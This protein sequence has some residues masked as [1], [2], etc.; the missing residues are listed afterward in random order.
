MSVPKLEQKG[1]SLAA[2]YT[3]ANEKKAADEVAA[4]RCVAC[5]QVGQYIAGDKGKKRRLDDLYYY[6]I[7]M[8]CKCG[9]IHFVY[10][11]VNDIDKNRNKRLPSAVEALTKAQQKRL[12]PPPEYE[13][14]LVQTKALAF[15]GETD[16]ALQLARACAQQFPD[17]AP[18][19][20]NYGCMLASVHQYEKALTCFTQTLALDENFSSAW[21][22]Q[23][24]IQQAQGNY[25][26]AIVCYEHFLRKYPQHREAAQRKRQCEQLKSGEQ[27][28]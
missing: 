21:Y 25:E 7:G 12:L 26:R 4:H 5:G 3:A 10:L 2:A 1:L 16:Q 9:F 27:M 11:V 23:A 8:K 22:Q 13:T 6:K 24:L 14:M 19:L 18:A 17:Q 15:N 20:Y 28:K